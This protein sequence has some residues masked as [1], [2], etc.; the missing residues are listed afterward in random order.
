[1]TWTIKYTAA[2]E[3]EIRKLD[4]QTALRI[5]EYMDAFERL[6]DPRQRGKSLA[7]NLAGFWR[8]RIGDYRMLCRIREEELCVLVVAVGHGGDIHD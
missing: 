5:V 7:G 2:A 6:D 1:M 8:Y 3:R 4:K